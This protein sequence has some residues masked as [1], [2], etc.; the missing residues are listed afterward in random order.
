MFVFV[1]LAGIA[2]ALHAFRKALGET[3][4]HAARRLVRDAER[5][6]GYRPTGTRWL[7]PAL[8]TAIAWAAMTTVLTPVDPTL[9]VW[10]GGAMVFTG[11]SAVIRTLPAPPHPHLDDLDRELLDLLDDAG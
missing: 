1:L 6:T 5:L 7:R 11:T 9:A 10:V 8:A 2:F 4:E 3:P